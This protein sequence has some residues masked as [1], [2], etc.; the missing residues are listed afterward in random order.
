MSSVKPLASL[1]VCFYNQVDFVEDAVHGV[2]SQTYDNLEIILSDDCSTDGTYD[3]ILQLTAD[4][5]G[6]HQ[7]VINKNP[8]NI[9][10]VP[11]VNKVFSELSHGRYIF[12]QGGDDISLPNRVS[13]GMKYFLQDNSVFAL[14]CAMIYIDR[15]GKETGRMNLI[16]D[17][18][19]TIHD[20]DYLSSSSFMCGFGML[21]SRRELWNVFGPLNSNCQT[22]DSCMRFRSLLLGKVVASS[23]FGVKYRIHGNNISIGNVVYKL[24]SHLIAEQ[25]RKDLM[26]MKDHIPYPLYTILFKKI[27]YYEKNRDIE[28]LLAT[29]RCSRIKNIYYNYK[30]RYVRHCFLRYLNQY[31][32]KI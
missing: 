31:Y 11:H 24:K 27:D 28:A 23:K 8:H 29:T 16:E 21:A 14:T 10:L 1:I 6:P 13:D 18:V 30:K 3:K 19:T 26:V 9:G 25:Y 7:V 17:I 5:K 22:E 20:K 2:L 15:N 12:V 32:D 4:Y